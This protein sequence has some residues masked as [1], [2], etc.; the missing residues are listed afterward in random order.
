MIHKIAFAGLAAVLAAGASTAQAAP[1]YTLIK[2]IAL[3]AP[4]HW[5]YVHFSPRTNQ[6]YIAHGDQVAVVDGVTLSVVGAVRGVSGGTHGVAIPAVGAVGFTDDGE[7]GAAVAFDLATLRVAKTLPTAPDA[8]GMAFDPKSGN[9]FVVAGDSMSVSVVDPARD[10]VKAT[11][12]V[13]EKMEFPAADGAG[14]LFIAGVEKKDLLRF[15]TKTNTVTARWPAPDCERP[16]G[17]AVDPAHRRIFMGCV[18]K[19]MMVMDA[20]SG[21]IVAELPIGRGSDAI[22]FDP[23][24]GRVFSSNGVDGSITVYEETAPD[25]YTRLDDVSTAVSGRTMAVDPK[26]G[27]LFVVAADTDPSP[28]PGG[29]PRARPGT[30]HLLVLA[31]TS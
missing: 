2:T 18:N 27:R 16:H 13:G 1:A 17:L 28:T 8:D 23:V 5:D 9:V 7:H 29:R 6:V 3:G 25:G 11:V 12:S 26:S 10:E 19:L 4:D 22:A 20:D 15:D 31:P 24:R 14:A 30:T 21:K